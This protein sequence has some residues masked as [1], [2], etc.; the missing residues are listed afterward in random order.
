MGLS[1]EKE[2]SQTFFGPLS[3]ILDFF[4]FFVFVN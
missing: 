1:D 2:I 3:K 4:F